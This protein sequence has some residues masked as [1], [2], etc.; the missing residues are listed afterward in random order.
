MEER[1]KTKIIQLV[2]ASNNQNLLEQ[3]YNILD[4][5]INFAEG[6][7]FGGLSHEQKKET[8]LS[9][10]ES[11]EEYNLEDHDSVMRDLRKQFGWS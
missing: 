5:Q 6:Q 8:E 4:S 10:N 11:K 2:N 7:L 1:L 3:I 9:L